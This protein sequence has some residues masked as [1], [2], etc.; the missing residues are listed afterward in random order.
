MD[1]KPDRKVAPR[2]EAFWLAAYFL[3][4]CTA[5]GKAPPL[6]LSVASWREAYERFYPALGEG[7]EVDR[8]RNSLK[9]ARDTFDAHMANGRR[10]WRD[11]GSREPGHLPTAAAAT[12]AA[13][14]GRTDSELF[15]AIQDMLSDSAA[16]ADLAAAP[17]DLKSPEEV[18]VLQAQVLRE[19]RESR[20][21]ATAEER[22][23]IRR[24][25]QAKRIGDRAEQIV[26]EYLLGSLRPAERETLVHHAAIGETPGYDLS[27]STS[28]GLIGVE[29]KGTTAETMDNFELTAGELEAA[30]RLGER[31]HLYL[32]ASVDAATAALQVLRGLDDRLTFQPT[33]YLVRMRAE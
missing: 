19:T 17:P 13:W 28:D 16:V 14:Q 23:S 11:S 31:Y 32:V 12:L 22:T 27:Y 21:S 4:R 6:Q 7:R 8:F 1:S 5:A 25:A 24:S 9:N 18:V 26:K 33:R 20:G 29:V 3:S 10:G 2:S 30:R 15:G